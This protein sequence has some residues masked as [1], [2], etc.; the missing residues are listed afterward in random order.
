MSSVALSIPG[1]IGEELASK[2][3]AK[4]RSND[5]LV[6]DPL[7]RLVSGCRRREAAAQRELVVRTQE[8]VYRT[9]YRMVGAQDAEDVAQQV[10]L[11]IFRQIDRFTGGASFSTWVYR[12]TINEA[13]Q[14]IRRNRRHRLKRLEG[15]LQD[16]Q[17]DHRQMP[18]TR[19]LLDRAL[20]D[21]EPDLRMIFLLREVEGLSYG[22]IAEA[23]GISMGTVASRLSRARLD[24]RERL[25][26]LGWDG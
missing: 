12:I 5:P 11:Q 9:L 8:R 2:S 15:D 13:L 1:R 20:A 17:P 4:A 26:S 22:A 19:E 25:R 6:A 14:H 3:V 21:I 23:L 16:R 24:L 7:A 10:Y 18:E